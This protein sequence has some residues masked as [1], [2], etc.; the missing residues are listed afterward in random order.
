MY[1]YNP[2]PPIPNNPL[3]KDTLPKYIP[4][5]DR[6]SS[7]DKSSDLLNIIQDINNLPFR[8]KDSSSDLSPIS[9][10]S[11]DSNFNSNLNSNLNSNP[12]NPS[13][14]VFTI[15]DIPRSSTSLHSRQIDDRFKKFLNSVD[16][17][18]D[19]INTGNIVG[20]DVTQKLE[21]VQSISK[22]F[23]PKEVL[24]NISTEQKNT[25]IDRE[26]IKSIVLEV[27]KEHNIIPPN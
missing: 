18:V 10:R 6:P 11:S 2:K 7:N 9:L 24:S 20:F 16:S 21:N 26:W 5:N 12:V 15:P 4:K 25:Q 14:K 19:T 3:H 23:H 17:A 8:K 22:D 13:N 27:L 1:K